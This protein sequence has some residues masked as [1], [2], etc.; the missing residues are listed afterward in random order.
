MMNSRT[1][2]LKYQHTLVLLERFLGLF[3]H[4]GKCF[5][6]KDSVIAVYT[7]G[8]VASSTVYF[9]LKKYLPMNHVYHNHVL[10]KQ[11]LKR[12]LDL[13][14]YGTLQ[15][16]RDIQGLKINKMLESNP[17]LR[18]K[19]ITIVRDPIA[20][21]ISDIFENWKLFYEDMNYDDIDI[22]ELE[23]KYN[24]SNTFQYMK[25]WFDEEF[26]A[27]TGVDVFTHEFDKY[28][29]FSIYNFEQFDML[30]MTLEGLNK[31]YSTAFQEFLNIN[32]PKLRNINTARD[33]EGYYKYLEIK[34]NL[35]FEK[36]KLEES[37]SQNFIQHF[38]T[39]EQIDIFIKRW[40]K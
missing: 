15:K 11:N 9:T 2:R 7:Y 25:K 37:Y 17:G 1:L 36:L 10:D 5:K 28:S 19:I 23:K 21:M 4:G 24:N 32:I 12:R 6:H 26:R 30:V 8:K 33:K 40:S 35:K 18:L 39:D 31:N 22:K 14:E 27:F 3:I 13:D 34:K 20:R 29:G 38:Y 16:N